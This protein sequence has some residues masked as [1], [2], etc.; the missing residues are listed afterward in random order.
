MVNELATAQY[1]EMDI[2]A[3]EVV[4]AIPAKTFQRDSLGR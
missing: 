1:T 4:D 3:F 2:Q